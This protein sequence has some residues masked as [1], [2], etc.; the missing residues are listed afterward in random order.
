MPRYRA[1]L[2]FALALLLAIEQTG[3]AVAASMAQGGMAGGMVPCPDCD[4]D[5]PSGVPAGGDAMQCLA[6]CA[7]ATVAASA[8]PLVV[9]AAPSERAR[10][11]RSSRPSPSPWT[12]PVAPGHPPPKRILHQSFQI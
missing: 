9:P 3:T 2:T 11:G 5:M 7:S 8:S 4:E 12:Q 1:V 6:H 10:A